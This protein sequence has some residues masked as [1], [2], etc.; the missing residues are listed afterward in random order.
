MSSVHSSV[1]KNTSGEREFLWDLISFAPSYAY[2]DWS[3]H[4]E[5]SPIEY[6]WKRKLLRLVP[7]RGLGNWNPQHPQEYECRLHDF[8][9]NAFCRYPPETNDE[10]SAKGETLA[11]VAEHLLKEGLKTTEWK[12]QGSNLALLM[13]I[14]FLAWLTGW[15]NAKNIEFVQGRYPMAEGFEILI[16]QKTT[17][18]QPAGSNYKHSQSG[19]QMQEINQHI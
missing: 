7:F 14:N 9:E 3:W 5:S 6:E 8:R 1:E 18:M 10:G 4:N 19:Q 2:P 13:F 15:K 11:V 12:C 17:K 16:E